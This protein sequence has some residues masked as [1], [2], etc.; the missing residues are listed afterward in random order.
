MVCP[1]LLVQVD[2]DDVY[3]CSCSTLRGGKQ[4]HGS[5]SPRFLDHK[6]SPDMTF[7]L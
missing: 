4:G 7:L 3:E 6:K 2:F 5:S 1:K